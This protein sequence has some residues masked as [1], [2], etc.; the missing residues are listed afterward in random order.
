MNFTEWCDPIDSKPSETPCLGVSCLLIPDLPQG[1]DPMSWCYCCFRRCL[2]FA[3]LLL[4]FVWYRSVTFGLCDILRLPIGFMK[5]FISSFFFFTHTL[6]STGTFSHAY[7]L[8]LPCFFSIAHT[9]T[10][11]TATHS[12]NMK[13]VCRPW[14]HNYC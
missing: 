7:I 1:G 13:A 12:V 14:V 6:T 8:S 5:C 2:F 11:L 9:H 3:L 4:P 10:H